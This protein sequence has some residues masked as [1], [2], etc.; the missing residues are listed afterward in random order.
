MNRFAQLMESLRGYQEGVCAEDGPAA[1]TYGQ[2]L[3]E[4][5]RWQQ[6]LDD[7]AITAPCVVGLR[8]DYS[9]SATA[10]LL[11]LLSRRIS[12]ALIPGMRDAAGYIADSCANFILDVHPS[13]VYEC[14]CVTGTHSSQLLDRLHAG[15]ESG[16]VIFTSGS[17]GRPKAALHSVERFLHKF[18]RPG[19]RMRTLAFLLF[20]HVAGL[21]TLFYT[22]S[23]GGTI[24]FTRRRD[25]HSILR[26]IEEHRVEVL[27]ASPSFLRLLCAV[28]GG[29]RDLSSLKIITYGSEPMDP[30]TLQRLN[31]RFRNVQ[32]SQK[33]GTTETG[34]P[35]TASRANDSLWVKIKSDDVETKVVNGVLWIRSEGTILGYLNAPSP[36]D[37]EG[38]YCTGDLVEVDGEWIRFRGRTADT[39]KVGGEKVA[40]AEVEQA[41]M[42]LD[43]VREAV[44]FSDPHPLMGC[45]VGVRVALTRNMDAREAAKVIRAHCRRRLASFAVPLRVEIVQEGLVTERQKAQRAP[46]AQDS[47]SAIVNRDEDKHC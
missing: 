36:L 24:I 38:W 11:A 18:R 32:I 1:Y 30:T 8:A 14:R 25:P 5:A 41:I 6:R 26:L 35:R 21:D 44:A 42:E 16:I 7:D 9:L 23:S 13:G 4:V 15:G 37:D 10:A 33:Y 40:P 47:G 28:D 27:P 20:D 3:D 34:S 19:R 45:V 22:L 46:G 17:T 12:V 2:L 31:A 43:M 39:I 29:E